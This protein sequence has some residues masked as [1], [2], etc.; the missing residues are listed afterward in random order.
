LTGAKLPVRVYGPARTFEVHDD[1]EAVVAAAQAVSLRGLHLYL[2]DAGPEIVTRP[3]DE[4]VA[5]ANFNIGLAWAITLQADF[6]DPGANALSL[7]NRIRRHVQI[8]N[9]NPLASPTRAS[10][11][12]ACIGSEPGDEESE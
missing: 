5:L 9:S 7:D 1:A 2:V 10:G 4:I 3:A 11:L 12:S 8:L 6:H